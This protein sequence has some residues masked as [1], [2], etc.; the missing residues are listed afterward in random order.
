[1]TTAT[2]KT[3][4]FT[5]FVNDVPLPPGGSGSREGKTIGQLCEILYRH[6]P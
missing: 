6:A 3:L 2:G 5:I 1:M 4:V